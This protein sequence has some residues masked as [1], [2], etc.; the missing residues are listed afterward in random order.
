M[1]LTIHGS[2][3]ILG[4]TN[5]LVKDVLA[6]ISN[7]AVVSLGSLGNYE[8]LLFYSPPDEKA[9]IAVTA[10]K[11]TTLVSVWETHYILPK[12]LSRVSPQKIGSAKRLLQEFMLRK[13]KLTGPQ[14]HRLVVK[15]DVEV[16]HRFVYRHECGEVIWELGGSL[17]SVA[18]TFLPEVEKVATIVEANR[19]K[20]AGKVRYA[21]CLINSISLKPELVRFF[22][23]KVIAKRL[24]AATT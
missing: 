20:F 10:D 3:R 19:N 17:N 1:E 6:V 2:E 12:G 9:K 8:Y 13:A 7:R 22:K 21:I 23:H 18:Y 4:R 15:I 5:M 11:R 24:R 14:L 16:N